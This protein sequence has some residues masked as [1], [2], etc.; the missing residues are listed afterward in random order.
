LE[1]NN[2]AE[3]PISKK[4]EEKCENLES[5]ESE[6]FGYIMKNQGMNENIIK[7]PNSEQIVVN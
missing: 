7:K 1:E 2:E 6:Q 5:Q 3:K 4:D